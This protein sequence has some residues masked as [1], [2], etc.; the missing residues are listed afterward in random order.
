[1]GSSVMMKV[2][3]GVLSEMTPQEV[4]E[5]ESEQLDP[6]RLEAQAEGIR[7]LRDD[8]LSASDWTQVGDSPLPTEKV[9][10]YKQYR[11]ELRAIPQ[12]EGF[13]STVTWPTEPE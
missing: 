10:L 12:Q 11:Q 4:A 7:K 8:L 3:N 1:M 5:Y 2:V 9:N 13:P 6:I